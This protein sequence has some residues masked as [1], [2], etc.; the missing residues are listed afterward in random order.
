[1]NIKLSIYNT[2]YLEVTKKIL[3]LINKIPFVKVNKK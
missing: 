1:M 2:K 3:T